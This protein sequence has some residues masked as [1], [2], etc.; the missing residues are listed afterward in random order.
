MSEENEYR[1]GEIFRRG[2]ETFQHLGN[3]ADVVTEPKTGMLFRSSNG[4]LYELRRWGSGGDC[5]CYTNFCDNLS[6]ATISKQAFGEVTKDCLHWFPIE[7]KKEEEEEM[8]DY[9]KIDMQKIYTKRHLELAVVA[10]ENDTVK[11]K[12]ADQFYGG[13]EFSQQENK[14]EFKSKY[15]VII[16]LSDK[17]DWDDYNEILTLNKFQNVR[18]REETAQCNVHQIAD[19]LEAINE[20]N[21]TNGNGYETPWPQDGDKYFCIYPDSTILEWNY[22]HDC[23]DEMRRSFGNFFRTREEAEAARE[24]VKK[25]LKGVDENKLLREALEEAVS[26]YGKPGG[27]WNVP[28]DAGGWISKARKALEVGNE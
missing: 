3:R 4:R 17:F 21:E 11:F 19:I 12:V 24:R 26:M 18:K 16:Q 5:G 10:V 2:G 13:D 25:A 20:Y 28:G 23:T 6:C 14:S 22:T 9:S 27:P 1:V 8:I 7:E 15:G